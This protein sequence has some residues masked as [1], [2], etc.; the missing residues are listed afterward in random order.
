MARAGP[1]TAGGP[2]PPPDE[3][4]GRR[5]L[6][7]RILALAVPALATLVVEPLYDLTDTAIVGHLGRAQLAGLALAATILNIV[8]WSSAFL[9]MAT[10]SRV[11]FRRARGDEA[12]VAAAIGASYAWALGLGVA[13]SGIIAGL[14][15]PAAA[16]L[17]GHGAV[18]R[19]A[20][21]YLRIAALG[22]PFLLA[23]YAGT[24]HLQG[25]EDTR[26]PLKIVLAAN[27]VNV[28][29]EILLVYGVRTGVAGSAWGTVAAQLLAA[30]AFVAAS[31]RRLRHLPLHPQLVEVKA[32]ARDGLPLVVRTVAL[33][34]ALTA[35][36]AIAARI[37]TATL[38][39][40]QVALQVWTL[41]ALVLDALAVPAQVYVAA[42]L[43]RGEPDDAVAVGS[44]CLRL[45][46]LAGTAVGALVAAVSHW[47]PAVFV[48]AAD[49]RARAAVGL[50]VCGLQQPIAALA[51]TYDGLL[52]GASGYR[53]LRRAMIVAL[54]AYTPLAAATLADKGLGIL[55]IW[56]AL[57]VWLAARSAFLGRHWS[58]R[59]WA[60]A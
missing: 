47:L 3:R 26:T 28:A 58:S 18:L 55:G 7:R 41:L 12:G 38:A 57:T 17:G 44:R 54:V 29:L 13:L 33:G 51:F 31:R 48:A 11:A 36:T 50:L 1:R 21:V 56:L 6:D 46:L 25:S 53:T 23:G 32:L 39:G 43:G 2:T 4:P 40:Q 24:G 22:M 20:T 19:A 60:G 45:A 52:L 8:G 14:G 27:V 34:A 16:L 49:V 42:A 5:A 30:G 35:S 37:D 59:A 10:T 9:A 15:P